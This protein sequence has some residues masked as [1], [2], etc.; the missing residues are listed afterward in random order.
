MPVTFPDVIE[1]LVGHL[2]AEIT[3]IDPSFVDVQVASQVPN[4]RPEQWVRVQRAG[5]TM[6]NRVVD[7]PLVIVE[8][9]APSA[10]RAYAL[11]AAAR[12]VITP[13]I[14][15]LEVAAVIH[16]LSRQVTAAGHIGDVV[17]VGGLTNLPDPDSRNPRVTFTVQFPI[18]GNRTA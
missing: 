18:T 2:P 15:E 7:E 14:A 3:T 16:E 12:V 4:P 8:A 10:P 1:F 5:G 17:E 13:V 9:W 6:R 11:A